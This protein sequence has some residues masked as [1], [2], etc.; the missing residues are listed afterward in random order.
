MFL[1]LICGL[2]GVVVVGSDVQESVVVGGDGELAQR[3]WRTEWLVAER[4]SRGLVDLSH[5]T[6]YLC[7]RFL[8]IRLTMVTNFVHC[9]HH[10]N[11]IK[12]LW[13]RWYSY[14]EPLFSRFVAQTQV[15]NKVARPLDN[16]Y[17]CWWRPKRIGYYT[18]HPRAATA[19]VTTAAAVGIDR[20]F[21]TC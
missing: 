18:A 13:P 15:N 20:N 8:P 12:T 16:G 11:S 4:R 5:M 1:W 14:S 2:C 10:K 7:F 17:P 3:K 9:L 21:E 6:A 19:E